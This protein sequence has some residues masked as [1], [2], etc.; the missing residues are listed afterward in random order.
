MAGIIKQKKKLS[1]H[2]IEEIKRMIDMGE[3]KEG[4]KLP[5]QNEFA[6]QLGISRSSL[7]EALHTLTLIGV[8]EQRP[9]T[10]TVIRSG[11]P[12]LWAEHLS[13]P[14]VSDSKA[15]IALVEARRYIEVGVAELAVQNA[16]EDEIKR[17][18]YLVRKMSSA[19]KKNKIKEYL[20]LDVAFHYHVA[21]SCHNKYMLNMLITIRGLMEQFMQEASNI[22]PGPLSRS[23]K[24]HSKIYEGMKERNTKKVVTN[25]ENHIRDMEISLKEYYETSQSDE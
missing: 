18:G 13:P 10:G 15:T 19:L 7:R 17:M 14:L 4:D 23:I 5:N 22:L 6:A 20:E 12:V 8:V 24:F 16:T 25:M 9:G 2:V 1:D 21:T 11:K 3:L